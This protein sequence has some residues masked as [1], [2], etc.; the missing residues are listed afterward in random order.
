MTANSEKQLRSKKTLGFVW[1]EPACGYIQ[2]T[3]MDIQDALYRFDRVLVTNI[4]ETLK[5]F[6][7]I[8]V[9]LGETRQI[10]D[11]YTP[12][13]MRTR[14]MRIVEN[15]GKAVNVMLDIVDKG[16]FAFN[17]ETTC[18]LHKYAAH[19]SVKTPGTFR[20]FQVM[21]ESSIYVPPKHIFLNDIFT[22]GADFIDTLES[23]VERAYAAFLFLSRSQFFADCNK[24]TASLVMNGMLLNAG[25]PPL[26][27]SGV[28]ILHEMA[29]FYETADAANMINIFAELH[30]EQSKEPADSP[31]L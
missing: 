11:G 23:P 14:D 3:G 16:I 5:T 8:N 17:K 2:N 31:E 1:E 9:T 18:L 22:R 13:K 19:D 25:Y 10:L 27:L 30:S 21:I 15:Y 12:Y 29:E 7:R 26:T 28:N 4:S 6:E 20:N 24:R